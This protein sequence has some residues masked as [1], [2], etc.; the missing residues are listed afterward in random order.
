MA[1]AS[2]QRRK[3]KRKLEPRSGVWE[4]FNRFTDDHGKDRAECRSCRLVLSANTTN[5][6][7][8]LQSRA[9]LC[10]CKG[11]EAAAVGGRPR[12]SAS[13]RSDPSSDCEPAVQEEAG[14]KTSLEEQA[15]GDLARMIALHGYDS[16]VVEDDYF[17][18][19]VR[20]L[21]PE[22]RVPSRSAIEE[23]CDACH[24]IDD[25][26]NLHKVVMDAYVDVPWGDFYDP[27]SGAPE[28]CLDPDV[29]SIDHLIDG[30]SGRDILDRLFMMA[31]GK[32][33]GDIDH[34]LMCRIKQESISTTYMDEVLHSIAS[35]LLLDTDDGLEMCLQSGVQ[36]LHLT[37]Q[38]CQQLLSQLGLECQW[39]YGEHWYAC[40]CSLEVLRKEDS[41]TIADIGSEIVGLLCNIWGK[42]YGAIKRI[43]ASSCPTSNLCLAELFNV[44]EVLQS[45]LER[46]VGDNADVFN[47]MCFSSLYDKDVADVLK[48][49]MDTLDKNLKDS[50]LVWSIPV[51]LDPRYKLRYLKFAFRR[52]F[53]S[54]EAASYISDVTEQITELYADYTEYV[55]GINSADSSLVVAA[56][57]NADPSEQA[58]DEYC[59]SQTELDRYLRDSPVPRT[60]KGFDILSWWKDHSREY[61]TV[62]RMARDALAMPTCSKLS[63]E[64]LAHVR[65]I[66]LGYSKEEYRHPLL[67][68]REK[69]RYDSSSDSSSDV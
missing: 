69:S 45:E 67:K 35:R 42:I 61:P 18:S 11:Q 63:S 13:S 53:G 2:T 57:D 12:P 14:H 56:G 32:M 65:S 58:W 62:S 9:R 27:F 46:T 37:R 17:R 19:F 1:E 47:E 40:Y 10:K 24:F 33:D 8:S 64:Q 22:F 59:R 5:G 29:Y 34:K 16:S 51:V 21:N 66:I 43:S 28:V 50:Y 7:S 3:R 4:H 60:T 38:K 6:T 68:E 26:W 31:R 20:R 25:E 36:D 30:I 39:A 41:S 15:S 49:A 48:D 23:I 52:A 44:R 55:G 54:N